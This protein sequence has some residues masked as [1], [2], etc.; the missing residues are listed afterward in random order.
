MLFYEVYMQEDDG[1]EG[2]LIGVFPERRKNTERITRESV[3]Q[4]TRTVFGEALSGDK[5]ISFKKM[6]YSTPSTDQS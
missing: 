5:I 4:W 2:E 6:P 3:L 1:K